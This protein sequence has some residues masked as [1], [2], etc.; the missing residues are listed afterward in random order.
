MKLEDELDLLVGSTHGE[1][2]S[3]GLWRSWGGRGFGHG[4]IDFDAPRFL[5]HNLLSLFL[6][7]WGSRGF[8][9]SNPSP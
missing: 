3:R 6:E 8:A 2:A 9:F 4:I 5:A 7:R 1:F